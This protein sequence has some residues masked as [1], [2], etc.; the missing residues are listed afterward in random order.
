MSIVLYK[1][2]TY[3]NSHDEQPSCNFFFPYKSY[4]NIQSAKIS[5]QHQVNVCEMTT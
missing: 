1:H 3:L 4:K 5:E 2:K